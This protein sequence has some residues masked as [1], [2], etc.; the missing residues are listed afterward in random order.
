ML[1]ALARAGRAWR[2]VCTSA[3]LTGLLAA[4]EAGLGVTVQAR[5]LISRGLNELPPELGLPDLGE[6]EFTVL[7][8]DRPPTTP[9]GALADLLI[10]NT[11]RLQAER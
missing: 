9:V 5:S 10:T 4:A 8:A 3:S 2:I 1:D 11:H 6:I 7:G